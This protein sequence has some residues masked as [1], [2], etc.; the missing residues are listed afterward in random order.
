MAKFVFGA[1]LAAFLACST[2]QAGV[3][4]NQICD[5]VKLVGPPGAPY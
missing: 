1:F 4:Q 5:Y 3:V 2:I